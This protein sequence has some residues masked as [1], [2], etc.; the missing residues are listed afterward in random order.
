MTDALV[1]A[2]GKGRVD[3]VVS[4][5][6]SG[7]DPN[8]MDRRGDFALSVASFWGHV[9]CVKVGVWRRVVMCV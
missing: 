7:V 4:L 3:E 5:L 1:R 9:G 6:A 8:A 2:S